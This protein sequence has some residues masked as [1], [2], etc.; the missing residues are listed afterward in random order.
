MSGETARM[1]DKLQEI[2]PE[3]SRLDER[4]QEVSLWQNRIK[5]KEGKFCQFQELLHVKNL[6][7][8]NVVCKS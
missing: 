6:R 7:A 3:V 5:Y 1:Q 2:L 4:L 8:T